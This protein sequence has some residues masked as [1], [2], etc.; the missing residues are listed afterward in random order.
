MVPIV[1]EARKNGSKALDASEAWQAIY[2]APAFDF[3]PVTGP[4][5]HSLFHGE[6]EADLCERMLASAAR[7][8][9]ALDVELAEGLHALR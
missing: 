6:G 7:A 8:R 4:E 5:L 1:D 9:G 3:D 2:A